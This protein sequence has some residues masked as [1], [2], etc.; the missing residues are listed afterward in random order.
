MERLG[1]LGGTFDP[2]HNGHLALAARS[3]RQLH[4]TSV[5]WVLTP[6]PPH[7]DLPDIT[8]YG[9]RRE[10]LETAIAGNPAFILSEVESERPGPQYMVDTISILQEQNPKAELTLLLGEDS[11]RDLPTWHRPGDILALCELAVLRRSDRKADM[12]ALE[13]DL[14]GIGA[15]TTFLDAAPLDISSTEIRDRIRHGETVAGMMPAAVEKIIRRKSL[16]T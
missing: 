12:V 16:Y 6:D 1:I 15:R 11:L 10:M 3:L 7:K 9:V 8:A 14:P 5:V 13:T 2:P 4:L